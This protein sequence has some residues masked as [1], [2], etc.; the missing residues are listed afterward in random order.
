MH[1]LAFNHILHAYTYSL[2]RLTVSVATKLWNT[3]IVIDMDIDGICIWIRDDDEDNE[4]IRRVEF[5][6]SMPIRKPCL[7]CI[8]THAYLLNEIIGINNIKL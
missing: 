6:I 8:S 5:C 3:Y 1:A 4:V 2:L 7:I